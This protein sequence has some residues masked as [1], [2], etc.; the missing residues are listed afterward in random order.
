MKY[1]VRREWFSLP[2]NK[3]QAVITVIDRTKK[4]DMKDKNI[5]VVILDFDGTIGNTEPVI[6]TTMRQTIS[7]LHLP[8]RTREQC[9]TMIGLPLR[10]TFTELI[11]MDE[12]TGRLCEETYRRLFAE[13]SSRMPVPAFPHVAETMAALHRRG[14]KLTIATSRYRA[15]LIELLGEMKLDGYVCYIVSGDDVTHAKPEPE[16]VLK[17]LKALKC[18]AD[19]VL[20]VGDA[21]YDIEMGRRAAVRTCAVTYG[22]GTLEQLRAARADYI[23]DDFARLIDVIDGSLPPLNEN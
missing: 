15:S 23:I 20:V 13:N 19:E 16:P 22:N 7:T 5:K 10:R 8:E 4:Y 11:P 6:T 17:T 14:I 2:T 9:V 12:E 3:P 18:P 1:A 21:R